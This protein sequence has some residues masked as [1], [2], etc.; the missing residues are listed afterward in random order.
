[1]YFNFPVHVPEVPGKIVRVRKGKENVYISYEYD[2]VYD[3]VR[4]FNIPKRAVIGKASENDPSLMYPNRNYFTYFPDAELPLRKNED[5]RSGCL[6]IGAFLVIRTI[7]ESCGLNTMIDRLFGSE[8]GLVLDLAAYSLICE[9]NFSQYY[10][11]YAYNHPLFAGDMRIYSDAEVSSVFS[12]I[13]DIHISSFLNGWNYRKNHRGGIFIS[14]YSTSRHCRAGDIS[15]VDLSQEKEDSGLPVFN[16]AVAYGREN[17]EPLFYEEC[18]GGTIDTP[19]LQY[20]VEKAHAY[21]YWNAGFILD[22]GRFSRES[23]MYMDESGC[24]FLILA[25]G[26]TPLASS[27]VLE[28]RGTFESSRDCSIRTHRVYAKTVRAKLYDSD[29][30]ERYCH[31]CHSSMKAG[32]EREEVE[33]RIARMAELISEFEGRRTA[34]PARM[35]DYFSLSFDEKQN[36]LLSGSERAEVIERELK[37]CG[38]FV[39]ITSAKMSAKEALDLYTCRDQDD[40]LFR[41]DRSFFDAVNISCESYEP[42]AVRLFIEFIALIIRGRIY[43]RL[44]ED[45]GGYSSHTDRMT[46]PAAVKEL[47]NIELLRQMDGIYRLDREVTARQKRLL[48]TFGLDAEQVRKTAANL[49]SILERTNSAAARKEP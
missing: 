48:R 36:L 26:T 29:M 13:T 15:I 41:G 46:V 32:V 39:I 45:M 8:G 34:F 10:S 47:E 2:R 11:D 3:A 30:K 37:L 44:K 38:Y 9:N 17:G 14:Y 23:I 1:M 21:G 24:D 6:K 18:P 33:T 20:M 4:K 12:S 31:I 49:S 25:D 43:R 22:R 19:Q 42:A 28:H 7:T 5:G 27:L 35:H 40:K 16:H